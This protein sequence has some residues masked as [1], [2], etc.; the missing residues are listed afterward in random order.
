MVGLNNRDPKWH[1]AWIIDLTTGKSRLVFKN[2]AGYGGFVADDDFNIRYGFKA[3]P[4]GGFAVDRIA[5]D[6]KAT[7]FTTI[8]GDDSLTTT[9]IGFDTAGTT[10]YGIE[11]RGRDKA[12]LVTF[13][14][15]TA[16]TTV[17]GES[18]KAD[19]GSVIADPV[20]GKVLGYGVTYLK[21]VWVAL[22]DSIKA[23]LQFLGSQA[24]G[25]WEITSQSDDG[26]WWI[27]I[28]DP[29]T[30][31]AYYWLYDRANRKL[32]KLLTIRPKLEGAPLSPMYPVVIKSRDGLE[33]VSFLT[34][35]RGS[36]SNNDGKPDR[37]LPMVLYVHGGPWAKDEYGY[38]PRISGWPTAAMRCSASTIAARPASAKTS[39]M[40]ATASGAARCT[41]T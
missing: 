20:T 5:A 9:I 12:A 40:P 38:N 22:D 18:N 30:E 36:D 35:P 37:P 6:G 14:P 25:E 10:L 41:T 34:L 2:E 11:S 32:T 26:K 29:V 7:P 4:D 27:V 33:L 28:H 13:D 24:S 23:D 17:L 16:Q 15:A 1:D 19:V 21:S 31:P 3:T 8:P 39:S